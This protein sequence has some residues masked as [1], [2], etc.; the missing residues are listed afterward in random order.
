MAGYLLDT[1]TCLRAIRDRDEG[2][3]VRF[4]AHADELGVSPI[5]LA[6]LFEGRGVLSGRNGTGGSS[7]NSPCA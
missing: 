6:A 5:S 7:R 2:L 1:D 4:N 3:R